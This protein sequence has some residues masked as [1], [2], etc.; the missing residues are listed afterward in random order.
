MTSLRGWMVPLILLGVVAYALAEDLTLTTYY[1]SP[2]GV[3]KEL[4]VAQRLALGT[5]VPPARLTVTGPATIPPAASV[6]P[7]LTGTTRMA[8]AS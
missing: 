4:R 3:Y 2:R 8:A 6:R 7:A 1:P 5:G